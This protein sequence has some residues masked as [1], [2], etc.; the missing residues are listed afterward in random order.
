MLIPRKL[1]RGI[2]LG[3]GVCNK[4]YCPGGNK[5]RS[6][7]KRNRKLANT[8]IRRMLKKDLDNQVD[9]VN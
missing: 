6:W 7:Y 9:S 3:Q 8:Q 5:M 4:C 2:C 1:L